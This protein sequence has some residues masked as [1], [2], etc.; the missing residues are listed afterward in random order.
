MSKDKGGK[1]IKK[2]KK[3][4]PKAAPK[5]ETPAVLPVKTVKP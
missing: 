1:N 5:V 3:I 4:Q 2:P